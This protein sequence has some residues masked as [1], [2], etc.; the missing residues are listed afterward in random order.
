MME[1]RGT[2]RRNVVLGGVDPV[3]PWIVKWK[4]I[5]HFGNIFLL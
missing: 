3:D 2:E 4:K 1:R 5:K